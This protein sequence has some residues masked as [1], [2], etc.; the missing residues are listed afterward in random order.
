V[1]FPTKH[2]F[3]HQRWDFPPLFFFWSHLEDRIL[4]P[5]VYLGQETVPPFFFFLP[6]RKIFFP[7]TKLVSTIHILS[8]V[9]EKNGPPL[10]SSRHIPGED[11]PCPILSS[12]ACR[13]PPLKEVSSLPS[14]P[15]FR[16][17]RGFPFFSFPFRRTIPPRGPFFFSLHLMEAA[18]SAR[19]F[20]KEV[21]NFSAPRLDDPSS[22]HVPFLTA[23]G[24]G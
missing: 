16:N 7:R 15:S 19:L 12:S 6:E 9:Q 24:L 14:P 1:S 5:P 22:S 23:T 21:L 13:T 2:H 11:V 20:V 17:E 18:L 10:F 8:R 4:P 3:S